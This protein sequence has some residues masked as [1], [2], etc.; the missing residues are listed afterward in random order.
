MVNFP[1]HSK[2]IKEALIMVKMTTLLGTVFAVSLFG[3][4]Q[5]EVHTG[6]SLSA[7]SHSDNIITA[8]ALSK[9]GQFNLVADGKTVCLWASKQIKSALHCLNGDAAQFIEL[10]DISE[11]N[12]FYLTSNQMTVRLYSLKS[13]QQLGEWAVEGHIINEMDI[14]ANGGK[15]LLGFRSGEASI[16]DVKR[17]KVTTFKKHRLDI[18]SVSLS[19]DGAIAFTGSSEKKAM[20]WHTESGNNIHEFKHASRVNHVSIS[21]DG[22]LGFTLDA[23]KDR[24]FW[25]LS[26]GN[27]IAELDTNLRFFEFNDSRFSADNTLLLTGSPKQIIKLWRVS[28]GAL[29]AEWQSEMTRGRSSVLG[30]A[31]SGKGKIVTSNSDGLFE[32]WQLPQT[33]IK[34]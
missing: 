7:L 29:M 25:D 13:K 8:S 22:K 4:S 10:L 19:D 20:L 31:Y 21:A 6:E 2:Y 32:Q 23:I 3:C 30:V 14:S 17:N 15:I 5:Q 12:Q 27:S 18:N 33:Q 16:I 1:C 9:D 26:T 11:N 24:T 28:D 34:N